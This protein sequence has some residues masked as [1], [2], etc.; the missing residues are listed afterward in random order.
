VLVG[1]RA[2]LAGQGVDL[3][4]P[5]AERARKLAERGLSLAFVARAGRA[6]GV[7]AVADAPRAD[8]AEAVARLRALGIDLELVSGDHEGAAR[9]AARAAGVDRVRAGVL[10]AEKVDAVRRAREAGRRVLVAGD[11]L[12]DAAALAAADVGVAMARGADVSLHAADVVIRSPRLAALADLVALSRATFR[13]IRENLGLA[14]AYNAVAIPLAV[15]GYLEPLH[16][17][18]TMSLSSLVVTGNAI[19]L[20]RWRPRP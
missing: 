13:R 12:N 16:A 7:V 3:E 9:L 2:L 14:L 4:P 20:L 1:T 11:G 17:A 6:L 8:A 5:L 10:P 18:V 15:A 19:R